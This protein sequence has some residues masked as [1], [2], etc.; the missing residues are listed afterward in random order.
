MC[1]CVC[2]SAC[3]CVCVRVCVCVCVCVCV[4]PDNSTLCRRC[5][6][7]FT[8]VQMGHMLNIEQFNTEHSAPVVRM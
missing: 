2:V 3:V 1:V 7:D 8:C 4:D 5:N 6:S